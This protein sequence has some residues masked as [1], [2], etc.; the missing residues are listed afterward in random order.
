[1]RNACLYWNLYNKSCSREGG[2]YN[3]ILNMI[4]IMGGSGVVDDERVKIIILYL[5]K[6]ETSAAAH[7]GRFKLTVNIIQ[8]IFM[9]RCSDVHVHTHT[10]IC[11]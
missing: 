7:G 8:H 9:P 11:I 10:Y 3:D 4:Y 1:M 2:K 6:S 5:M